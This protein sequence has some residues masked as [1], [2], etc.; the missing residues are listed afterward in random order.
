MNNTIL[1]VFE[2]NKETSKLIYNSALHSK[3]VD[4]KTPTNKATKLVESANIIL[5]SLSEESMAR[6]LKSL[7]AEDGEYKYLLDALVIFMGDISSIT[8][9]FELESKNNGNTFDFIAQLKNYDSIKK[10]Y[11]EISEFRRN[12]STKLLSGSLNAFIKSPEARI[13]CLNDYSQT[14]ETIVRKKLGSFD[15]LSSLLT[16]AL[17]SHKLEIL[18]KVKIYQESGWFEKDLSGDGGSELANS[19]AEQYLKLTSGARC[20]SDDYQ[21]F[22]ISLLNRISEKSH[23]VIVKDGVVKEIKEEWEEIS[24]LDEIS[25]E[26]GG[27]VDIL[28]KDADPEKKV[29]YVGICTAASNI[30]RWEGDQPLSHLKAVELKFKDYT[31]KPHLIHTAS[32]YTK[33]TSPKIGTK[34]I[35]AHLRTNSNLKDD[36]FSLE[37]KLNIISAFSLFYTTRTNIGVDSANSTLDSD[38][39][40]MN[41]EVTTIGAENYWDDFKKELPDFSR[42]TVYFAVLNLL[43]D[44]F[45]DGLDVDNVKISKSDHLYSGILDILNT[46]AI[47]SE[48]KPKV[49][50]FFDKNIKPLSAPSK[51]TTQKDSIE[52]LCENSVTLTERELFEKEKEEWAEY[53]KQ[54][55]KKMIEL[56]RKNKKTVG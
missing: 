50:E 37:S 22:A 48:L 27:V 30:S 20:S 49:K 8:S 15:I 31:I 38:E 10:Y 19:V 16:L 47:C 32:M 45:A 9:Q 2:Y 17:P 39:F 5:N 1:K 14:P 26:G 55:E 46:L 54:A 56:N 18:G 6:T 29:A 40:L 41:Y 43:E 53:Q 23:Q 21:K 35:G 24:S 4:Y 3:D 34:Y 44:I 7:A 33:E 13:S 12:V 11:S 51:F 25:T 52:G 28:M 36:N 42:R